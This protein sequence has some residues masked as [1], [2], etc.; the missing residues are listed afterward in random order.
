M[1]F[2]HLAALEAAIDRAIARGELRGAVVELGDRDGVLL[3]RALGV[4]DATASRTAQDRWLQ[5]DTR[6]DLASLSKPFT[7]LTLQL[8]ARERDVDLA[9]PVAD[10]LAEFAA[11]GKRHI[12]IRDLLLHTSGLPAAN[13]LSDYQ[14]SSAEVRRRILA[15]P[16]RH[17]HG[18]FLYSDVN[19]IV[20]G[21]LIEQ[22]SGESLGV[23]MQRELLS[24]L[25]LTHTGFRP[26]DQ[27]DTSGAFAPTE[28]AALDLHALA[29][30]AHGEL[31]LLSGVV[32]DPRARLLGG[33][34]GHAGLFSSSEDLG[35]LAQALL[36]ATPPLDSAFQS[37][38]LTP[39]RFKDKAW[40]LGWQLRSKD[41]KVFGH[42]GFTGTSLWVDPTQGGYASVLTSRLHPHGKGSADRLRADVQRV[43]AAV[44]SARPLPTSG[45]TAPL[46]GIDV[47]RAT[48][49]RALHGARV[50]LLTNRAARS[51]DGITSAELLRD[52]PGVALVGLLTPEHGLS[53]QGDGWIQDGRDPWTDLPARSLYSPGLQISPDALRDAD[54]VVFDLQ[55]VGVRFY[56]YLST[57]HGLLRAAAASHKRVV[58]LDRT[59]PLGGLRVDGPLPDARKPSFVHHFKLPLIHGLT[60]GEFARLVVSV[61]QLDVQLDVVQVRGWRRRDAARDDVM[62]APPSPNLRSLGAVRLYPLLGSF[63]TSRLSVGRGTPTP[64]ELLGAPYIDPQRLIPELR[65]VPGLR[66]T[67]VE[68]TPKSSTFQHQRCRGLRLEVTDA[69]TFDPLLSML[70][71]AQ[72]LIRLYPKQ[73]D[74]TRLDDLLADRA[75]LG[76][77]RSGATPRAIQLGWQPALNAFKAQRAPF[78]LYD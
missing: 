49:F 1:P 57:L 4:R 20:L 34:A 58:V 70:T 28:P 33:V 64:F 59:N 54:S 40:S 78:L 56:T 60:A 14:G 62:W 50:L 36:R 51:R 22:L 63:E 45:A 73:F 24:P 77:L 48:Q 52:A 42:Y 61:E 76:L 7:A 47:L 72:A 39:A 68:F 32:H 69:S 74:L 38:M 2:E 25:H 41:P 5:P 21:F 44:Y 65:G 71:L 31:T 23:S 66:V 17:P 12:S 9:L 6:F 13:A 15:T 35:S 67:A 55:D 37:R 30:G 16:A 10:Y 46:Q 26:A 11:N 53:A 75:T 8:L 29:S 3:R 18:Q 19:Y 43:A 27:L